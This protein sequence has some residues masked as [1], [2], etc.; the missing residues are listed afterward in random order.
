VT[1]GWRTLQF[2]PLANVNRTIKSKEGEIRG[3]CGMHE[4][5]EK[6]IRTMLEKPEGK[7]PLGRPGYR[8]EDIMKMNFA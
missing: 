6:C 7:R 4:S 5:H 3:T 8:R 1:G 2:I